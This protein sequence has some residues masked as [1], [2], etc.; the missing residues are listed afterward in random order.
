MIFRPERMG[1]GRGQILHRYRPQ[2]TFDHRTFTAQVSTYGADDNYTGPDYDPEY[3]IEQAMRLVARWRME[4]SAAIGALAGSDRAPGF[5]EALPLAAQQYEVVVPGRVFSRAWPLVVRCD[6]CGCVYESE[7]P[8]QGQ[9]WPSQCP[10]GHPRARQLQFVF[11]HACGE[12]RPMYPP[13]TPCRNCQSKRYELDDTMSRFM[14]FAWVCQ[15]CRDVTAVTAFCNN[16]R[17][18]WSNKMMSPQVH[19]ASSAYAGQGLTLVNVPDRA[20]ARRRRSSEYALGVLGR[21]V[22]A[23]TQAELDRLLDDSGGQMPEAVRDALGALEAAGLTEQADELRRRYGGIDP[24]SIRT[25]VIDSLGFDPTSPGQEIR[26]QTLASNLDLYQRI[27]RRG[28]LTIDDLQRLARTPGRLALYESYG[29]ILNTAGIDPAGTFLIT[30]FPVIRLAVGY[31][32]SGFAAQEADLVPYRGRAHR[33]NAEKTLLFAHPTETEALVFTLDLERLEHW[34]RENEL[35][36]DEQLTSAGGLR[37]WYARQLEGFDGQTVD[38]DDDAE[39]GSERFAAQAVY[40]L[41]HTMAHQLLRAVSVDSGFGEAALSEYLFPYDFAFAVYPNATSEFTI[42]GL[43]TVIEQVL[44]E[45]VARA[46]DNDNCLYD[47]NCFEMGGADLG[48]LFLPETSC[49]GWNR[50]LTRWKLF[51]GGDWSGYWARRL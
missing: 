11:V 13:T 18:A 48:C 44:G 4:G 46:Q 50:N 8:V 49:T 14:D 10:N 41:L 45:V 24:D 28:R 33:G 35:V 39:R 2:Q 20:H 1:R 19:T 30:S 3:L 15:T 40:E 29:P 42:G 17:C 51:G 6:G 5:P 31:A 7:E 34:L 43:R 9:P 32:R 16:P 38:W 25:A 26:A 27:L 21:F 37:K 22:G 47:P 12:V 23:C 36:R